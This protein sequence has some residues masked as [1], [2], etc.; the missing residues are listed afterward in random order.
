[1]KLIGV[2]G[3]AGSGKTTFSDIL[4]QKDD[5]GVIH[6]DVILTDIKLK[7]FKW[8][9]KEDKQ[10]D[11]TK[12]NSNLKKILYK[13]KILFRMF[14]A[15]RAKLIEKPLEEEISRLENHGKKVIL[16]DDIFLQ[17][18]ACYKNL[19]KVFL[20]QRPFIQRQ[21]ALIERDEL[22]K[23]EVVAYDVAHV[24]GNYKDKYKGK[25]V[26]KI[27]NNG[28]KDDLAAKAEKIYE[29][30]F[31]TIREKYRVKNKNENPVIKVAKITTTNLQRKEEESDKSNR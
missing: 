9:M 31:T 11:K 5:I 19:S 20:I 13:N 16:I 27:I 3:K 8:L 29:M 17:Y 12:V 2:T 22:T 10:G 18:Q 25:N 24:S 30:N 6:I 28:S 15:F 26:I 4:S 21:K 23:E 7:Y 1:M 14:M